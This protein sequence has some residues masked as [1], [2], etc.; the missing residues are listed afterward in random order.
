MSAAFIKGVTDNLP[1]AEIDVVYDQPADPDRI[2]TP[3]R[4]PYTRGIYPTMYRGRPWTMRKYATG[5][6]WREPESPPAP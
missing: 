5:S 4:Y 6:F 2:G 3:G 1:E